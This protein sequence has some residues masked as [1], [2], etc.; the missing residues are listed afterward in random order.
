[1]HLAWC[2]S[3]FYISHVGAIEKSVRLH[4]CHR[5]TLVSQLRTGPTTLCSVIY[6]DHTL[7][8]SIELSANSA[9]TTCVTDLIWPRCSVSTSFCY[10]KS[11][12]KWAQ[13]SR[14]E[15]L[16]CWRLLLWPTGDDLNVYGT[17][18]PAHRVTKAKKCMLGAVF[19]SDSDATDYKLWQLSKSIIKRCS[20]WKARKT[21]HRIIFGV[22]TKAD[23]EVIAENRRTYATNLL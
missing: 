9:C 19:E 1:M 8:D 16:W 5:T 6:C 10:T 21:T 2:I 22:V 13:R 3:F 12:L 23:I 7:E 20:I 15:I 4:T 11:P 18:T 14:H 17:L